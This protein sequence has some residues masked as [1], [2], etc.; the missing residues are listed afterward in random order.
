M[1]YI[2]K[3]KGRTAKKNL[4]VSIG[5]DSFEVPT[6]QC[7][8]T[9]FDV[10]DAIISGQVEP[11]ELSIENKSANKIKNNEEFFDYVGILEQL[12]KSYGF[13]EDAISSLEES[14]SLS[15]ET[16]GGWVMSK[17]VPFVPPRK[18]LYNTVSN[19]ARID[20]TIIIA[21][22]SSFLYSFDS[23]KNW[24]RSRDEE[25]SILR[26]IYPS[27]HVVACEN[28]FY[29]IDTN[30]TLWEVNKDLTTKISVLSADDIAITNKDFYYANDNVL[31]SRYKGTRRQLEDYNKLLCIPSIDNC[32]VLGNGYFYDTNADKK[33]EVTDSGT[34]FNFGKYIIFGDDIKEFFVYDTEN[35]VLKHFVFDDWQM[36]G[37]VTYGYDYE[38]NKIIV[39][40]RGCLLSGNS[41][42]LSTDKAKT[43]DFETNTLTDRASTEETYDNY[44]TL[45]FDDKCFFVKKSGEQDDDYNDIYNLYDMDF[46]IV[47]TFT[48]FS[49]DYCNTTYTFKYNDASYYY[50]Y[51]KSRYTICFKEQKNISISDPSKPIYIGPSKE[52]GIFSLID[53]PDYDFNQVSLDYLSNLPGKTIET[54]K[55]IYTPETIFI[56]AN[57]HVS[58]IR[59]S[60]GR[61][62]GIAHTRYKIINSYDINIPTEDFIFY[63]IDV[64]SLYDCDYRF[65]DTYKEPGAIPSYGIIMHTREIPQD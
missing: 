63:K 39:I 8:E 24:L 60:P 9:G 31:F 36:G 11:K 56:N 4:T 26:D 21:E 14:S 7:F 6:K 38:E 52:T 23:G 37:S 40:H 47:A 2:L 48:N 64:V 41:S 32:Y 55:S 18:N 28:S 22:T 45:N 53:D 30:K 1:K 65:D 3:A 46:N 44:S 34:Y 35:C 25:D 62:I 10:T 33:F 5:Q 51:D 12:E 19:M 27:S 20:D 29:I 58:L 57:L 61:P 13:D 16:I 15:I 50:F 59:V 43:Y 54:S 17:D 42:A 49:R